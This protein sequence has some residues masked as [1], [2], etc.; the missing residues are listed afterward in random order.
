MTS[1]A[2]RQVLRACERL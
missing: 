2:Q 1:T